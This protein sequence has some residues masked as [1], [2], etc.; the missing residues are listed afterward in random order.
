L[1]EEAYA[2]NHPIRV[3]SGRP[4]KGELLP[5]GSFMA[6]QEGGIAVQAIKMPEDTADTNSLILRGFETDG[7]RT[8]VEMTFSR[9]IARA[10]CVDINERPVETELAIKIA[11]NHVFFG[12][13]PYKVF[14]FKVEF[15]K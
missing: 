2:C 13:E 14:T 11:D 5:A 10:Y 9:S 3:L 8:R 1:I 15:L 6:I 12:V 7:R 4:G